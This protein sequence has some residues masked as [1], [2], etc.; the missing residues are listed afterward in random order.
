MQ[1]EFSMA[2]GIRARWRQM[3]T[4]GAGS[5]RGSSLVEFGL[6][7]PVLGLLLLGVV[8]MGRA[9]YLSIEVSN[10]AYAGARYG[11]QNYTDTT[12][13]QNAAIA[14]AT[15]VAGLTATATYGCVCSQSTTTSSGNNK[16]TSPPTCTGN[17][18]WVVYYA[19]VTTSATYTPLFTHWPG[20]PTSIPL[21]G[22]AT[23]RAGQD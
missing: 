8:D 17:G 18:N 9:F 12:G 1:R 3:L 10:A 16:C 13:M 7:I 11:S 5:E 4:T 19:T 20:L 14:D 22:S 15:D 6:M 2:K 23:I 21:G